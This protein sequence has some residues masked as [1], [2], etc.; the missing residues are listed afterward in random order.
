MSRT[1]SDWVAWTREH[2]VAYEIAPLLETRGGERLQSGFSVTF[3]AA[4]PMGAAAGEERQAAGRLL[5]EELR[6]LA[7]AAAPEAARQARVEL[8]PPHAALLRPENEFKPEVALTWRAF[9]PGEPAPVTAEDRDR[10]AAFE[11]RL[12]ELGLK[13]GRW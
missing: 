8:D 13:R 11:K 5:L 4:A 6:A 3:Y 2:R 12:A 9:H 7:E 1:D 10:L